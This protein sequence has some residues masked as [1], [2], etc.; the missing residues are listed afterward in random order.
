MHV[1]EISVESWLKLLILKIRRYREWC[2]QDRLLI[3]VYACI[4]ISICVYRY[5]TLC[6]YYRMRPKK[7]PETRACNEGKNR[8]AKK[9]CRREPSSPDIL[10]SYAKFKSDIKSDYSAR[11]VEVEIDCSYINVRCA[12]K[13]T[14]IAIEGRW[15]HFAGITE[16][17]SYITCN[18]H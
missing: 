15:S 18:L 12:C 6:A 9:K 4:K 2:D 11:I 7:R 16:Y 17:R 5:N 14:K 3:Y 8:G 1:I 13:A 10:F